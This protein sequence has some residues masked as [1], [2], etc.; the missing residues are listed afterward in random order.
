MK[1]MAIVI[2]GL[3]LV[4]GGCGGSAD[5]NPLATIVLA[6]DRTQEAGT[7]RMWMDMTM[8]GPDGLVTSTSD[9]A[10]DMDAGHGHMTMDMDM[11][12]APAGTPELG[13][14]EAVYA[15]TTIYMKMPTLSA[16]LPPGKPWVSLD[17]QA[18]G[19]EVGLDFGAL[20]QSGTSDPT[21]TLQYLRGASGEVT[22]VGEET[23]RG[24]DATHYRA[25][26]SLD[27][28]VE[29]AP[30]DLRDRLKPTIE[31]LK[32]WAG[33]DELPVDVWID[34]EGRMVR[35]S[36]SFTYAAGPAA[37]T[38]MDMTLEMYDF[39]TDVE[40]DLPP[41]SEVTDLVELMQRSP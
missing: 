35:Q 10:F 25:T 15:G 6:A 27:K 19:E 39:G 21:Q 18:A 5:S 2:F 24:A 3:I 34:D 26:I 23:V 16:H 17:L 40:V 11:P 12:D 33:T 36:Q 30:D 28:I 14:T 9:G 20:M 37:G 1:R 13:T 22:V 29:E 38:S 4:V 8:D 7:A 41:P 31:L 32:E